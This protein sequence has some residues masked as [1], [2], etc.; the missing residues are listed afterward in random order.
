MADTPPLVFETPRLILRASRRA[1]AKTLY[2]EYTGRKEATRYL[3]R[4]PH[5]S[6]IRTEMAIDVWGEANWSKTSRFIWSILRRPEEKPVGLF[7]MFIEGSRAEIHYGLGPSYWGQGL[8]SEA[9]IAAMNWVMGESTIS[10]I[11]TICAA[12]H[13]ASLRVLEKI[14][15]RR[16]RLL[17]GELL[18]ASTGTTVDA[19]LCSWKRS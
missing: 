13:T 11:S 10:E 1:D 16:S 18:L 7:L 19:W 6:Q 2:E 8:A 3:Q 4:G 12:E 14:G 15:L 17:S 9:G 5:P